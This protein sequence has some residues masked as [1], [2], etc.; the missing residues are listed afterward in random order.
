VNW[1]TYS[2]PKTGNQPTLIPILHIKSIVMS[3][4]NIFVNKNITF[5]KKY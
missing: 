3:K 4:I 1:T 2:D 5:I